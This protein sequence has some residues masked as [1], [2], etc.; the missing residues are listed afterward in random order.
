MSALGANQLLST[1]SPALSL[2]TSASNL[3]LSWPLASA[4]YVVQSR[5][6]LVLGNWINVPSPAPPISGGQWQV[7]LPVSPTA[8][9][10][11]FEPVEALGGAV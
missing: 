1:E 4:G 6:N 7:T 11:F 3:T 10:K 8:P 9:A 2:T 5:P